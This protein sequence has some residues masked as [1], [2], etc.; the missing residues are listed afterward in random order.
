MTVL[1]DWQV[2]TLRLTTFRSAPTQDISPLWEELTGDQPVKVDAQPRQST[3]QETGPT[4]FGTLVHAS[5]PI[6]IDW[7]LIPFEEQQN[8]PIPNLG[9]FLDVSKEFLG[10]M[11]KWLVSDRVP[12]IKRIAFGAV[13]FLLSDSKSGAYKRLAAFLP[14]VV[15]DIENSSD[16]LYQI[17]RPL[18]SKTDQNSDI[19]RLSK[20]SV[21][22]T[23]G[24]GVFFDSKPEVT[25]NGKPVFA[26]R[27]ELDISTSQ[28]STQTITK[29][30]LPKILDELY[31]Y[32]SDI[33]T[34]GDE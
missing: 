1:N 34:K 2:Q 10:L 33:A 25:S 13:L 7:Y 19:N 24:I 4:A 11:S 26:C 27:L 5:N 16:F 12:N 15:L 21:M 18:K 9:S 32:G 8:T 28:R 23:I 6:R 31:V 30:Q 3:I 17:N 22:Q 29:D 14:H 20:W